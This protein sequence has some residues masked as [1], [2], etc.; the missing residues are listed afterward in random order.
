VCTISYSVQSSIFRLSGLRV[1]KP[2]VTLRLHS[3]S[4][5]ILK[6]LKASVALANVAYIKV[7]EQY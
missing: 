4:V 6:V 3:Q 2:V 5:N 1:D 7:K